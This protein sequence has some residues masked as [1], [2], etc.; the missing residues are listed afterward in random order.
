MVIIAAPSLWSEVSRQRLVVGFVAAY[1]A[2]FAAFGIVAHRSNTGLYLIVASGLVAVFTMIH[3]FVG[4]SSGELRALALLG[5][6]HLA[7]G[8]IPAGGDRILYNVAFPLPA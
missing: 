1:L 4:L 8:L 3:V 7:G 5:F 2:G 6:L